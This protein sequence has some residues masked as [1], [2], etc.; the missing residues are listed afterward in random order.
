MDVEQKG[1]SPQSTVI[2]PGDEAAAAKIWAVYVSEA[3]KYDKA[4]VESWKSDMEGMLIFAGLFS[5]SLTAFLIESYKTLNPDSSNTTVQLLSQISQQLAAS[6]N[7]STFSIPEPPLFTPSAS[8]LICN[9]LWFFSLGLALSCALIATLLEQWARDFLHRSEIRSAPLIRA[10]IFSF[11]Y[12]GL[13]RFNMHTVVEVIPLLLHASLLFFFA[14]LVAFLIP[15][16][17]TMTG[18]ASAILVVV[19]GVYSVLTLLPLRYLDCPYRTP[20]SGAFWRLSRNFE[21]N[22]RSESSAKPARTKDETVVEAISRQAMIISEEQSFRDGRAL[23]W[24]IK[25]LSDDVELDPF[26]EAIPDVLWGPY[27][28]RDAYS[29]HFRILVQDPDVRLYARIQGLLDSCN[30]GLLSSNARERR[31]IICYKAIWAVASLFNSDSTVFEFP[32]PPE[33]PPRQFPAGISHYSLSA[34]ELM[35]W[36]R[37]KAIQSQ[38]T[39]LQLYLT[40]CAEHTESGHAPDLTLVA[41]CLG[42]LRHERIFHQII[43][44]NPIVTTYLNHPGAKSPFPLVQELINVVAK[45]CTVIPHIIQFG[46]LSRAAQLDSLPYRWRETLDLMHCPSCQFSDIQDILDPMLDRVVSIQLG[47]FNTTEFEWID[48]IMERSCYFWRP[49]D[50]SISI[51]SALIKY[52]NDRRSDYAV[53]T[54]LRAITPYLWAAFPQTLR[55]GPTPLGHDRDQSLIALWRLVS[56]TDLYYPDPSRYQPLM[57]AMWTTAAS[58]FLPSVRTMVKHAFLGGLRY[59]PDE[60]W[61]SLL[62]HPVLPVDTLTAVVFTP[63]EAIEYPE[64]WQTMGLRISEAYVH[65]LAEFLESCITDPLPFNAA[66]TIQIIGRDKNNSPSGPI[67]E[68]HQTSLAKSIQHSFATA[69]REALA[70]AVINTQIFEVYVRP[71][72]SDEDLTPWL[73]NATAR[74]TIKTAFMAFAD[75]LSLSEDSTSDLKRVRAILDGLDSLHFSKIHSV[76]GRIVEEPKFGPSS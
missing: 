9:A 50:F 4:L 18:V 6:A 46:Y 10:R 2:D 63:E 8:S 44:Q 29:N 28:P 38:L 53:T 16:N 20:L 62:N 3:E 13:K 58:S 39:N 72:R 67:H 61:I 41:S 54:T 52:L 5:A 70:A 49:E 42:P 25:S 35:R 23:I 68:T 33:I 40:H 64:R 47:N 30:T 1:E 57:D 59:R 7:G 71:S 45:V 14:G 69:G 76:E 56:R 48:D 55:S 51:P 24:T 11:L 15:V 22:L 21:H 75:K 73:E 19:T 32:S 74:E 26:V 31:Q 34:H 65:L 60:N 37:F 43:E 66:E 12:Y 27:K 17:A 36:S